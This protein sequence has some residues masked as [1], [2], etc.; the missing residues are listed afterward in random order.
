[1]NGKGKSYYEPDYI[2]KVL[3]IYKK[4]ID[5]IKPVV[6]GKDLIKIGIKPNKNMGIILKKLYEMQLNEEFFTVDEGLKIALEFFFA[7]KNDF[8]FSC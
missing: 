7:W 3:E 2:K 1:M 4:I 6:S 5:E 8:I